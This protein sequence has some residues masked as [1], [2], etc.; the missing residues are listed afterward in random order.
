MLRFKRTTWLP[1][2]ALLLFAV[3]AGGSA[4]MAAAQAAPSTIVFALEGSPPTFDPLQAADSRVDTPSINL[5]NALVQYKAGT[6]DTENDLA[7]SVTHA[8]DGLTYTFKLKSGVKFHDGSVLTADDVK[9]TIDRMVALNLGVARSL[10]MVTGADVVD[11]STVKVSLSAP[12]PGFLGAMARVYILN[13]KLVTANTASD[14]WGQTWLQN[15][16]AGTGP[17]MLSSFEPEQQFT[18]DKFADY[19][20]GWDGK[21]VD[22]AIFTVIKE[23]ATRRLA[24]ENGQADWI[25]VGSPETFDALKDKPGFTVNADATLNQLYFAFNTQNQYL[26]DVR[27]RKALALVYDYQGHVEQARNGHADIARGPLPPAIQCFDD[28]MKPSETNIPAAKQLMADAGYPDGGF[29]LT[30]AYQGTAPEETAAMQ[31]WQAGAAELGV[32]IKPMAVEWPAKVQAYSAQETTPDLGTIWIFPS[33]P[34]PDQFVG[35]LADSKQAGGGGFN[36]SW[37]SNPKM[38]ELINAGKTELDPVKR[39]DIYKQI[40]ELWVQDVPYADVVVGQ[41]LSASAAYVKGYQWSP[42]HSYTQNV[43]QIWIEK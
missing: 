26:K 5:Y 3:M 8:D 10:T 38:D 24:L 2:V 42:P 13:S 37:Y 19:F 12:F 4:W 40:Q 17:Y 35:L 15:H 20:K 43:Y 1:V 28:A 21:H 25:L 31:I 32:T 16:D 36:F 30:M 9:Y 14:D 34:D 39:C 27:V 29:E 6:A 11:P 18:I 41:A 22:R 23:E 7:D 33:L